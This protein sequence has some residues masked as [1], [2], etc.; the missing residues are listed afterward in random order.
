MALRPTS[1]NQQKLSL[2]RPDGR[3]TKYMYVCMYIYVLCV[4]FVYIYIMLEIYIYIYLKQL[5]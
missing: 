4:C 5:S 2:K 3:Y 1:L